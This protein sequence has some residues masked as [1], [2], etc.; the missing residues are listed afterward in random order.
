MRLYRSLRR[1]E[2]DGLVVEVE[3]E[4]EERRRFYKLTTLGRQAVALEAVRLARLARSAAAKGAGRGG[5]SAARFYRVLLQA[6]PASFRA[7]YG[8]RRR[9]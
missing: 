8:G 5:V 4:D 9:R 7:R 6:W 1:L 3:A 2:R